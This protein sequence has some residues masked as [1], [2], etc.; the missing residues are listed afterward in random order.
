MAKLMVKPED[1][2]IHESENQFVGYSNINRVTV[3]PEEVIMLFGLRRLNST[4]EAD[5]V[6]K[7]V[8]SLPH[9]KRI[10]FVLAQLFE[11]H[12]LM[13]GEVH[14]DA[15]ARLTPFGIER[16]KAVQDAQ[17]GEKENA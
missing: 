14:P 16:V 9:A 17:E 6:A 1:V 13:F 5:G 10:L 2:I 7:I 11:E 3:T 15:S 8:L 12:E 4:N